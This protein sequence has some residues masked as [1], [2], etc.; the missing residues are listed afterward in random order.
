MGV[1]AWSGG[2][3]NLWS[4]QCL[5]VNGTFQGWIACSAFLPVQQCMD[6]SPSSLGL[7]PSVAHKIASLSF[8]GPMSHWGAVMEEKTLARAGISLSGRI[9][10][11]IVKQ[12]EV[13]SAPS[14]PRHS[15]RAGRWRALFLWTLLGLGVGLRLAEYWPERSLWHDEAALAFNLQTRSFAEL[16]Q[17]LDYNQGAPIGFLMLEKLVV[18]GLGNGERA[19]RLVPF[20]CSVAALLIFPWVAR[21]YVPRNAVLLAVALLA[22]GR[23][24]AYYGA[25]LKQYS[26]DLLVALLLL[27]VAAVARYR[28]DNRSSRH[29]L[30]WAVLGA[31]AVWFSHSSVFVLAGTGTCYAIACLQRRDWGRLVRF[32]GV[33]AAW[34]LSFAMFW[35]VALGTLS[36]NAY[37]QTFWNGQFMPLPPRS[38]AD[39]E[40]FIKTF[41]GVFD[42]PGGFVAQDI[43]FMAIAVLA[44]VVGAVWMYAGRPAA[45][46]SLLLPIPFALLA[47]GLH[48]YP[49]GN[50]LILFLAPSLLLVIAAGAER[51][52][53]WS[54]RHFRLLG[55][56][57]LALLFAAPVLGSAG[58]LV[59]PTDLGQLKPMLAY[60]R[61]HRLP[62]DTLYVYTTAWPSYVYYAADYDLPMN[63]SVIR[64][65]HEE[66]FAG[67]AR[68]LDRLRGRGRV[69]VVLVGHERL[70]SLFSFY[71]GRLGENRGRF[72]FSPRAAVYLY[73]MRPE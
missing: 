12:I 15:S 25:Q 61:D 73:D 51:I 31:L 40:W 26:G 49:F 21:R 35:F 5:P 52:R 46:A 24:A 16:L 28:L 58:R 6:E 4:G 65:R 13:V 9:G 64:G 71:L 29:L 56:A 34:L 45:L 18:Q 22:L 38:A 69:W 47:S 72:E 54:W 11:S 59:E 63:E 41:F 70:A 60:V 48:K 17:P 7:A 3:H 32:G 44:F 67:Y 8:N 33:V 42:F 53:A 2:A 20:L 55:V 50:R 30:G 39:L 68:D 37:M 62:G 14:E 19:L 57:F 27:G 23:P 36:Q 10:D 43:S 1:V 66:D